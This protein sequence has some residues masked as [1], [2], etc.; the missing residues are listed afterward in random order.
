MTKDNVLSL[1]H[2]LVGKWFTNEVGTPSP[3][4]VEGWPVI[5]RGENALIT[6]PTG[7]GKTLSAFLVCINQLLMEG[8]KGSLKDQLLV[9]YIS[10]LKA[11]N[12]DIYRNLEVPLLGLAKAFEAE[13]MVFPSI[14]KA[15]RTGDTTPYE[16][17]KMIKR[18]P[19]IL[20]TT[21]ES[22]FLL[23]TADRSRNMLRS[24]RYVIVD[25]IHS[26]LGN[27]RGV[28]LAL[29]LERLCRLTMAA[30][31]RIGL[32]ATVHPI[33]EAA[34]YLGGCMQE[35]ED[36][37]HRPV[38]IVQP[39]M[40]KQIDLKIK[41]PVED[42]RV[43]EE[44]TI[45]PSIY[46]SIY[47]YVLTH[48]S[49]LVF[50]NN[51]S[52][53]ERVAAN[54]NFMAFKTI[55]KTHHGS[56]SK[57]SRLEVEQQ[58]KD[59]ALPCLVATSS[60]ELG[61]DVGDIDLIV[62][63]ASPKSA[64]RGL[65]RLGR[66]G[67]KLN[68][69]S[70]GRIIPRTRG[71][72]L[73]S[74]VISREMLNKTIEEEIVPKNALDILAQHLVSMACTKAWSLQEI[75]DLCRAAYP[76]KE[77]REEEVVKVLNMLAGDYE[78]AEDI[79]KRPRVYW[80][81]IHQ[82][83]TGNGYSK[84]LAQG[85][86]GTIP[87]RGYYGVYLE[88][89]TTGLG[90]LDEE[91]VFEARIN[92]RFLLG[93]SAWQIIRIERDRVLVKPSGYSGAK[94]PFWKGDGLGRP[95]A[96]GV[97]YGRFL[98][99]LSHKAE[100]EG[101]SDWLRACVPV[102]EVGALN[103]Q[104][105]I[106]EQ[107]HALGAMS[108]ERLIIVEHFSDEVG[109]ARIVIHSHF[110]GRVNSGLAILF[111]QALGE[112]LHC[113][114]EVHHNDD[115]ILIHLIGVAARPKNIF[116]LLS[117]AHVKAI[118]IETLPSTNLYAMTFRYNAA[119]ALMMGTTR[120]GRRNPLWIQRLRGLE[121]LKIARKYTDHPLV[122]ETFR[123]CLT[124][125]MDVPNL[126]RIIQSVEQ[127]EIEIIETATQ[128][129][130]PF[131]SELLFG[132]LGKAMYE[133]QPAKP[134]AGEPQLVSEEEAVHL[135]KA[136]MGKGLITDDAA[137]S[138]K[139][140]IQPF[141]ID[142]PIHSA[143]ALHSILLTYG[144]FSME[145][146][147]IQRLDA[148]AKTDIS[149]WLKALESEGRAIS[150]REN[151]YPRPLWI[152]AEEHVLYGKAIAA[153][154]AYEA[155]KRILRRYARYYSPFV[156]KD[157]ES[158]Y[159]WDTEEILKA[160]KSLEDEQILI[161]GQFR[162]EDRAE[163]FH[164][165][166]LDNMR[167]SDM[168]HIRDEVP[169]QELSAFADFLPEWQG[170]GK[171]WVSPV[172]GLLDV[173]LKLR[174]MYLPIHWWEDIVFPARIQ[175]YKKSYL[176]SLCTS[177]KIIW[178]IRSGEQQSKLAF[179]TLEDIQA[180]ELSL[181]DGLRGEEAQLLSV[182][183]RRG[184]CFLHTL[185]VES[186][187]GGGS[188]LALLEGLLLQGKVVNDSYQAVRFFQDGA[189]DTVK[190]RARQ[191]AIA[192][193]MEMGRWEIPLP[194]KPLSLNEFLEL[195]IER[196]GLLTKEI[197]KSEDPQH[198]W[199]SAYELLKQWEYIGKVHR[200]YFVEG[201]SGIQFAL[202]HVALRLQKESNAYQVLS[203][204]DPAQIYGRISAFPKEEMS[205]S[206]LPGTAVVLRGGVPVLVVERWGECLTLLMEEDASMEAIMV[207]I[208]A[209]QRSRIWP[210][211][212]KITVKFWG[213]EPVSL[214]EDRVC[215]LSMGFEREMQDLVLWKNTRT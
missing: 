167:T 15:I 128:N 176:D 158:R 114:L 55:A 185:A 213:N 204:C 154:T 31:I 130:S 43:L 175:G 138:T 45:W 48:K 5:A 69:V 68:A 178:R 133:E 35:G 120:H 21:P 208:Q 33:D 135:Q 88:D 188:L 182:L 19:H 30:P 3:P 91:F 99:E 102:C 56:V 38:S 20:I 70:K 190:R 171:D 108:S 106:L 96:L 153:G 67:H 39:K 168:R 25:E 166:A 139:R 201:L 144:D 111:E 146:E 189:A 78:H 36:W 29:S 173:I 61:I 200:G 90:E 12:N 80:D 147:R 34:R 198:P 26:L 127:G 85:S 72:L 195:S 4:Q 191:S 52:S 104:T 18:P 77:V 76:Y 174:G 41:I 170:V 8:L 83:M 58:L 49:T 203:G 89:R 145:D 193:R 6:A 74:V 60:L 63:V 180:T 40:D 53:A 177:G 209:F 117:S 73:D 187:I 169:I 71:D 124:Y 183:A 160:L 214:A 122:I 94:T 142:K 192:Y 13:G 202:P 100:E 113:Q 132:F 164:R 14:T 95:Y 92:D 162:L 194:I 161:E 155:K 105:Y 47:Q 215:L 179:Y 44:G 123:E 207:F 87:D 79:P 129:P 184:A 2:P 165:V 84:M 81:R 196:H 211:R 163:W 115:G 150:L 110:G 42:Y 65:Q 172:D 210:A 159:G 101:F 149:V 121:S 143:N 151:G 22:L 148:Y 75:L 199:M 86:G 11:L 131:T 140:K 66:A 136:L 156:V 197:Y 157:I 119:R 206:C 107:Q 125:I 181:P 137:T 17:Q 212:R 23:L 82:V 7:A 59:G 54:L 9:L 186:G 27:K 37:V 32:S 50:V 28:H 126:I 93:T 62:Q 57:E 152:A 116:S 134:T 10:P 16:R 205:W 109:D 97:R 51:R 118:L 64:A 24:V 46:E 141:H 1:F 103:L 112:A 98:R